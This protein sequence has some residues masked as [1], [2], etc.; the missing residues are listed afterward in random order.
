MACSLWPVAFVAPSGDGNCVAIRRHTSSRTVRWIV[1]WS[2]Q[3]SII[4]C[5]SHTY[6]ILMEL[7]GSPSDL[8][9]LRT[10]SPLKE[11]KAEAL[12]ALARKT[13][14][15]DAPSGRVL[16]REGDDAKQ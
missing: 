5:C 10:F 11:M 8:A 4:P 7:S 16:I 9:M 12:V 14:R 13:T 1:V 6:S 15:R 3:V 2:P